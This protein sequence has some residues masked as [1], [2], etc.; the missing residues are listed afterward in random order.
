MLWKHRAASTQADAT[1]AGS[2]LSL[3]RFEQNRWKWW[4]RQERLGNALGGDKAK[5]GDQMVVGMKGRRGQRRLPVAWD[6]GM[7]LTEVGGG[8]EEEKV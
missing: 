8:L 2:R 6:T 5:T 3:Q 1:V 7:W 4:S